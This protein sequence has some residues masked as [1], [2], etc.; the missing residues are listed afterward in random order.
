MAYIDI[1]SDIQFF[2]N[3]VYPAFLT[4]LDVTDF[5]LATAGDVSNVVVVLNVY[6]TATANSWDYEACLINNDQVIT[7]NIASNVFHSNSTT[8]E[9][10]FIFNANTFSK[11]EIESQS[12]GFRYRPLADGAVR[13]YVGN[14]RVRI[15]NSQP[16]NGITSYVQHKA[17]AEDVASTITKE[18]DISL[19]KRISTGIISTTRKAISSTKSIVSG[20]TSSFLSNVIVDVQE[21]ILTCTVGLKNTQ[22]KS[23]SLAKSLASAA[24]SSMVKNIDSIKALIAHTESLAGKHIS[25]IRNAI[26]ESKAY[27]IKAIEKTIR[28][29]VQSVI[30]SIKSNF[31]KLILATQLSIESSLTKTVQKTIDV[32]VSLQTNT[33]MLIAKLLTT[34]SGIR[35]TI[36]TFT[37]AI[38]NIV[39]PVSRMMLIKAR[40]LYERIST[41]DSIHRI[42]KR[43]N[44]ENI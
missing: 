10:V 21:I 27:M 19:I 26:T 8:S 6:N 42:K 14:V 13:V 44:T 18:S 39:V 7:A 28:L 32:V 40:D 1:P 9:R 12:F 22:T 34:L 15:N 3:T 43:N 37:D 2:P 33:E 20:I 16:A 41:R 35:S 38:Q 17:L 4:T 24:N 23:I 30:D 11:H 29:K 5:G 31:M 25:L 36:A